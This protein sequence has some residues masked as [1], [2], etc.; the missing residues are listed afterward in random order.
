MS[1][2][3]G[4]VVALT[5]VFTRCPLPD[6]CPREADNLSQVMRTLR[7]D[8]TLS[9]NWQLLSISFEPEN[10]PPR[11]LESY[12]KR[13]QYDP[14]RWTFATGAYEQIQPLGSHFGLYFG[15]NVSPDNQNHNLRTVVLDPQ[16]RVADIIIGNRWAPDQ[17]IQ[18]IKRAAK[19]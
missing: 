8:A 7:S 14:E 13:Y 16:G 15:R 2:L 9:T 19:P 17:V 5:F 11:V 6:F 1:E 18:A 12:A 4:N 3:R 10:D